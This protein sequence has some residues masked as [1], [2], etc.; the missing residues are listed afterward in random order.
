MGASWALI[1]LSGSWLPF[2]PTSAQVAEG[3]SR[4][5]IADR[6]SSRDDYV[7]RCVEVARSLV[8]ERLM[9]ERDVERV[10]DRARRMYSW[11]I[12]QTRSC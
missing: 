12:D 3:D 1:G 4:A 11:A 5:P 10:V 8:E 6:Y 2:A 7:D 9:L